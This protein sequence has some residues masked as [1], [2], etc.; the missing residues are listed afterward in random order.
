MLGPKESRIVWVA[1]AVVLAGACGAN[2]KGAA[3][4]TTTS[5]TTPTQPTAASTSVTTAPAA[6]A[7]KPPAAT[8]TVPVGTIEVAVSDQNGQPRSGVPIDIVGP[9]RAKA[10]SDARGV[11]RA[12]V[13]AADY[14]VTAPIVC[15]NLLNVTESG[16]GQAGVA[17]GQTVHGA[18]KIAWQH[19]FAPALPTDYSATDGQP[20]QTGTLPHWRAGVPYD[21]TFAIIDRC[22]DSAATP[23]AAY[24]SYA[25]TA[26]GNT[27]INDTYALQADDKGNGHLLATCQGT[28]VIVI[29]V[30]DGENPT[31]DRLDLLVGA[32]NRP[33]R[34]SCSPN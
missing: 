11:A 15:T 29:S 9:I 10:V 8:T 1:V 24:A 6:A 21:V 25:F 27:T 26:S 20:T 12:V 5:T 23:N 7:P 3:A 2:G 33:G 4:R 32:T 34:P 16:H 18:L 19:R 13:P 14:E 17:A 30:G 28:G 31:E 22:H